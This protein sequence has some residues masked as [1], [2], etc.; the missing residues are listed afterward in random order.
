MMKVGEGVI[1]GGKLRGGNRGKYLAEKLGKFGV[2]VA[3][4]E[5][6]VFVVVVDLL[7]VMLIFLVSGKVPVN[8]G[9]E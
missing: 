8:V 9:V 3:V 2:V 6:V 5:I 1:W 4:F 7:L